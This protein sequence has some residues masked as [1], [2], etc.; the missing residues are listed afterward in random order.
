MEHYAHVVDQIHF[1]IDTIKAIIK[2]TEIYL[3][4][5]LNGG[6]PIEHL[7]EHYSLLDTEEGRLSGLNEA[8]NI[9]QSQLLKYK[10]DQQ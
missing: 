4:K 10:S 2:E 3:H 8:L 9:L 1:R 5:Q 7:S 6:V